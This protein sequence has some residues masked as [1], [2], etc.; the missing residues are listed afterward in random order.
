M[1]NDQIQRAWEVLRALGAPSAL[2]R[3]AELVHEAATFVVDG[4]VREG[5]EF[6]ASFVLAGAILHDAG[7]VAH[8]D[9]LTA[10]G[11]Q[12]ELAGPTLLEARGTPARLARVAVSHARWRVMDCSLEELLVALSDKLWRGTREDELERE[13]VRRAAKRT[14][15]SE[16]EAFIKLDAVF[17]EAA[18]AGPSRLERAKAMS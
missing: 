17:E 1:Q 9:E 5:I 2:I 15:R 16:W 10:P 18:A 4:L 8:P 12:H 7:K 13:V 14:G 6:D 11:R 3:H